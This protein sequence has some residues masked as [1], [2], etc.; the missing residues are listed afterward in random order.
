[1]DFSHQMDRRNVVIIEYVEMNSSVF[2]EIK[3]II[4]Y[5]LYKLQ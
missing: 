3:S 1:M 5:A 2:I 4:A